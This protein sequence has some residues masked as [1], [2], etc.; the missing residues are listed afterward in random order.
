MQAE[1]H[2]SGLRHRHRY[3]HRYRHRHRR[4]LVVQYFNFSFSEYS[5]FSDYSEFV[6][7][8]DTT[9]S[10]ECFNVFDRVFQRVDSGLST[11]CLP[12]SNMTA[13]LR[14]SERDT[15]KLFFNCMVER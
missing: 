13:K 12:H 4:F 6:E 7:S 2:L 3:R 5:G 1:S 14:L 9:C 11:C 15:I 10:I 8:A